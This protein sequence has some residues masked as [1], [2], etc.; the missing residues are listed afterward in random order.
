MSNL[1]SALILV[2]AVNVVMFLGQAAILEINPEGSRFYNCEGSILATLDQGNCTAGTY[3]LDDTDPAGRLP[4]GESSVSPET[5]NVFTDAF[6]AAKSWFLDSLGLS[7][8]VAIL[9]APVSF[10]SAI[11]LPSAFSF[12][13]G[14]LWYGVTLF[15]IVAFILGRD[16]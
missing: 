3:V 15:L 9:A 6:T 4:S 7:Y 13:V 1:T 16:A 8:L 11:G 5:G 10:L 14:V 12:A 2:L